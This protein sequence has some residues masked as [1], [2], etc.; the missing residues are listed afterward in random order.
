MYDT[1]VHYM[2]R[3]DAARGPDAAA[4]HCS[5]DDA[6]LR[7]TFAMLNPMPFRALRPECVDALMTDRLKTSLTGNDHSPLTFNAQEFGTPFFHTKT[8]KITPVL[9]PFRP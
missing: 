1:C 6:P 9:P 7:D 5:R 3:A 2:H 4:Q 8:L